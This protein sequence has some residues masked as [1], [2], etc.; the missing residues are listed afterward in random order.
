[1]GAPHF[2]H[3][4]TRLC[5]PP[6]AATLATSGA[7][8]RPSLR[9]TH[10]FQVLLSQFT[11]VITAPPPAGGLPSTLTTRAAEVLPGA[12]PRHAH[13]T[14][15]GRRRVQTFSKAFHQCCPRV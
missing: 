12:A 3:T 2:E 13:S 7:G 9:Q 4:D 11:N 5:R 15:Y 1:M 6:V 10:I 14:R 8:R